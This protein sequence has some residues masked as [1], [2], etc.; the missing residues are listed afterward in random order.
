MQQYDDIHND[1]YVLTR[2]IFTNWPIKLRMPTEDDI[3]QYISEH[4]S[5]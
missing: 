4:P 2:M 5:L 1:A 3:W